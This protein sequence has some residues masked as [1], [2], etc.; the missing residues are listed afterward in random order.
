MNGRLTLLLFGSYFGVMVAVVGGAVVMPE[1][2]L[3]HPHRGISFWGNYFSA[4][5]PY[6]I[7]LLAS[8]ACLAYAAYI[9]PDYP[10][11]LGVMRRLFA[12]IAAGLAL[13]LLTPE[14]ANIL[15]YWAHTFAAVYL[16]VITGLSSLWIMAQDGKTML[17]WA[18]FWVL[19][20]GL[21][22][23]LLS[24]SLFNVFDYLALGQVMAANSGAL[25]IIR[26]T[27]RWSRAV[28][29]E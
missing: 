11:R 16:F 9:L 5:V 19:T 21:V 18:L 22:L 3:G 8:I 1:L 10:E 14:Q 23:S 24:T 6:S 20:G 7:G 29:K 4:L 13:V 12:A 17:D 26:A 28:A 27:A 15:F 2:F 25:L